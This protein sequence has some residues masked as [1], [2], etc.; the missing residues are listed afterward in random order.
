MSDMQNPY[1][2]PETQI[3]PETIQSTGVTLTETMLRFLNEAS[4]W[5][6][7]V[8]IL[9]YIGSGLVVLM[10][11]L[12]AAGASVVTSTF[13]G[14]EAAEALP[15]A[16]LLLIYV[17]L[18]V[19]VFFPAHFTFNFGQKIRNYKFSNSGEDLEA[20]FKNNKS[21]WK[22]SGIIC[23]IYLAFIPVLIVITVIMGV[24]AAASVL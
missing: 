5:L 23:I 7:F 19:L 14:S 2:T 18:G 16:L 11:V 13:L 9:G 24:M 20:A 6:R 21:L 1:Q 10:G 8:G 12:G 4:P 3:V 17:P 15:S 22:F